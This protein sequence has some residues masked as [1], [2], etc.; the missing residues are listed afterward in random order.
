MADATTTVIIALTAYL[1][2]IVTE[3]LRSYFSDMLTD[4]RRDREGKLKEKDQFR[5]VVSQMPDL[6]NEIKKDLNSPELS[7]IREFFISKKSYSLN[8]TNPSFVY[9]VD[10]HTGLL[11]KVHILENYGYVKD[12]TPG[13]APMYRMTENFVRLLKEA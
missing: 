10:D 11:S 1:A 3:T 13:N 9:Y 12:V 8:A 4:R 6:I 2:G 7:L 5:Y